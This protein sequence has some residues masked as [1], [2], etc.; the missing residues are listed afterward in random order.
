MKQLIVNQI[1]AFLNRINIV[2]LL[3]GGDGTLEV[4]N[5]G[6]EVHDYLLGGGGYQVEFLLA[7]PF[8]VVVEFGEK[9]QEAVVE[10]G[11]LGFELLQFR[12]QLLDF[13]FLLVSLS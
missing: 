10:L 2:G 12:L 9:T 11:L 1:K 5:D 13:G 8:F 3:V 4:V 6:Q 7:D